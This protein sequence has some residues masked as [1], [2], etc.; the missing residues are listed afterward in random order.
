MVGLRTA[1]TTVRI[2]ALLALVLVLGVALFWRQLLTPQQKLQYGLTFEAAGQLHDAAKDNAGDQAALSSYVEALVREGN[3]GRAFYLMDLYGAEYTGPG[4]AGIAELRLAFAEAAQ[5]KRHPRLHEVRKGA[6]GVEWKAQNIPAYQVLLYCDGYNSATIGDWHSA[7][8]ILSAI[9][10]KRLAPMLRPY[11]KYFLA[12]AYRLAGSDEQQQEVEPLLRQVIDGEGIG[13]GLKARARY[14][15]IGFLLEQKTDKATD[16]AR[17]LLP[18]IDAKDPLQTWSYMK[19]NMEFADSFW[20]AKDHQA[21]W[22]FASDA[23]LA[24]PA[25]PASQAAGQLMLLVARDGK[26]GSIHDQLLTKWAESAVATGYFR[27]LHATLPQIRQQVGAEQAADLLQM[28]AT[29]Y[30]AQGNLPALR[31]LT[32]SAAY[33]QAPVATKAE[34]RFL[35]AKLLSAKQQW[36]PAI[37]EHSAVASLKSAHTTESLFAHYSI[38]KDVQ[39]PL[40]LGV[41]IPLLQRVVDAPATDAVQASVRQRAAEELIPLLINAGRTSEARA[42]AGKDLFADVADAATIKT[43]LQNWQAVSEFWDGYLSGGQQGDPPAVWSYYDVSA[44]AD[45]ALVPEAGA[46]A[47]DGPEVAAEYFAGLGLSEEAAEAARDAGVE[48]SPIVMYATWRATSDH[49]NLPNLQ[50]FTT[51]KLET[52][53]V[54]DPAVLRFLLEQ[55]YPTPYKEEV[56]AAAKASGIDPAL[57]YAVMKK[58]SNFKEYAVSAVGATGLMQLMPATA[59]MMARAR[60]IPSEP[61]KDPGVNI[62]LGSAYL[63]SLQSELAGRVAPPG[64]GEDEHAALI[65]ATLHCYNAGPGNYSKWRGLYPSANATLLADLIPNEENEGFGKRVWKYYLIYKWRLAQ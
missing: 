26:L 37:A 46:P 47:I 57:I 63:G 18:A 45:H 59:S 35:L 31:G 3:F 2:I 16:L 65:R 20:G 24:G 50:W 13:V 21:A 6:A 38:L 30:A 34:V 9:E 17:Q 61:L 52:G 55:A 48:G 49:E 62:R 28:E 32:T 51:E 4:A 12:R 5:A 54:T 64:P 44:A 10:E 42:I 8:E 33:S 29:L 41:A 25:D 1:K 53:A 56:E 14:N 22:A 39:E 23:L 43:Q 19:A 58:E 11:W 60:R 7:K 15:L 40:N 36:N 27:D